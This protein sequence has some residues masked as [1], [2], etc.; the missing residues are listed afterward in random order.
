MNPLPLLRRELRVAARRKLTYWARFGAVLGVVLVWLLLVAESGSLPSGQLS[1]HLFLA[2]GI[3]TLGFCLVTGI[4]LT[5]DCLSEEK[6]EGTLGLLFLTDLRGHDVVLGKL[7]A[8]SVVSF[9]AVLAILPVLGLPLLMGGV[10]L[11][12]FWR[13]VLVLLAT[14]LLSLSIG[15]LISAVTREARQAMAGTFLVL[16]ALA[17]ILPAIYWLRLTLT[18]SPPPAGIMLASP[19]HTFMAAFASSYGTRNGPEQFWMSLVLVLC[20]APAC[21]LVAALLLPHTWQERVPRTRR[22]SADGLVTGPGYRVDVSPALRWR[23]LEI[24]PFLWA[25][26]RDRLAQKPAWAAAALLFCLW[27]PFL[28]I[29]AAKPK[30]NQAFVCCLFISYGLHQVVKTMAAVE[31]TRRLNEERRCGALELLLVTPL[32]EAYILRG[33]ALSFRR[34]LAP[35]RGLVIFT[36]IAMAFVVLN[37]GSAMGMDGAVIEIFLMLFL[38]GTLMVYLDFKAMGEVGMWMSLRSVRHR[39][40]AFATICRVMAVNWVAAFLLTFLLI[41]SRGLSEGAVATIFAAWFVLG[42]VNDAIVIGRARAELAGGLRGCLAENRQTAT[43][44]VETGPGPTVSFY[45]TTAPRVSL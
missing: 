20:L 2:F 9:F 19:I 43:Q 35:L 41:S 12:E 27:A 18:R 33:L 11:G 38:G 10:T 21:L 8:T 4:F 6:R 16:V 3:I 42:V 17:G 44:S 30:I 15:M 14:L 1:Q 25:A 26:Q 34:K 7:A 13:L 37:W 29:S 36:N 24:N 28:V 39:T 31:A 5:A 32:P 23:L 45:P 22:E 40:A